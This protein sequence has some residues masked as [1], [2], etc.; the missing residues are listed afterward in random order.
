MAGAFES[1]AFQNDAFYVD[2]VAPEQPT[3]FPVAGGWWGKPYTEKEL[4]ARER[5][6]RKRL[7]DAWDKHRGKLKQLD[8]LIRKASGEVP[9]DTAAAA[10]IREAASKVKRAAAAPAQGPPPVNLAE[11][12]AAVANAEAAV[13][14]HQAQRSRIS[15]LEKQLDDYKRQ[16]IAELKAKE[17]EDDDEDILL[18]LS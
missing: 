10:K 18:L 12:Y 7:Q 4:R 6:D 14:A 13:R 5:E 17:L 8:D 9:E 1:T 15:G 11:L 3:T 2:S 16:R